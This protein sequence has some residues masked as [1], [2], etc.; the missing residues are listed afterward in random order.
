MFTDRGRLLTICV[1]L[2]NGPSRMQQQA[3]QPVIL[4]CPMPGMAHSH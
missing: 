4:T 3:A 1:G 2:V